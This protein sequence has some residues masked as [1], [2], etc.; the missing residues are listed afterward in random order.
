[1]K[2]IIFLDI[3]GVLISKNFK[4]TH[5]FILS[6]IFIDKSK[7]S[8]L[9]DNMG[10]YFDPICVENLNKLIE[11]TEADIVVTSSNR[12][13]GLAYLQELFITREITGNVIGITPLTLKANRSEEIMQ[14]VVNNGE[15]DRFLIYDDEYIK[16][17]NFIGIDDSYGLTKVDVEMGI[18]IL[19]Q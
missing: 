17:K 7:V 14:W 16:L 6:K 11:K 13:E 4:K 2:K 3:D 15:P 12:I 5:D 1:V 10:I 9:S 8:F 18:D 19:N